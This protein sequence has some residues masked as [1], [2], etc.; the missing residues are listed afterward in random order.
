MSSSGSPGKV[1]E[2]QSLQSSPFL[3]ADGLWSNGYRTFGVT[4]TST[5]DQT[6]SVSAYGYTPWLTA[7]VDYQSFLHELDQ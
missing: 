7:H 5:D 1:G 6:S 2:Y 3:D 4:A